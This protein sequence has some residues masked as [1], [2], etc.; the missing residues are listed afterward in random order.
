MRNFLTLFAFLVAVSVQAQT[1][2]WNEKG[3]STVTP[4][5]KEVQVTAPAMQAYERAYNEKQ[6]GLAGIYNPNSEGGRTIFGE[7]YR[8][9]E[10]TASHALLPLGTLARVTNLDNGR[11]VTVRINDKGQECADCLLMLSSAAATQLGIN[12][13]ARVSVERTGFSNW[14]PAPPVAAAPVQQP[15]TY[16]YRPPVQQ[17][18]QPV[19]QQRATAIYPPSRNS[20]YQAPQEGVVR[21]ATI[22]GNDYGW[23]PKTAQPAVAQYAPATYNNYPATPNNGNYATLNAPSYGSSVISREVQPAPTGTYRPAAPVTY[24]QQVTTTPQAYRPVAPVTQA[25]ISV[26]P[27]PSTVRTYQQQTARGNAP[28]AYGS[29]SAPAPAPASG[30]YSVQLAAYNNEMYAQRRVAELQ[31]AG[32]SGAY[33]L[34]VAKPDGQV[35]NRVYSGR[36]A[37]AAEAQQ[38]ADQIRSTMNVAGI[39]TRM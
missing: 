39:V 30:N 17:Q 16:N 26:A 32:M 9:R 2:Q 19:Q 7:T 29:V 25:Q 34:S 11:E 18:Q 27:P 15:T 20:G 14:N 5:P 23:E 8:G 38:A 24:S 3:G 33:Y 31:N 21:P 13:R 10:L 12:Y 37:G 4:H 1:F 6:T 35:I 28:V 22:G 36:Y